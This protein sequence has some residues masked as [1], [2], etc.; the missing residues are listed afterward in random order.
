MVKHPF[1][2]AAQLSGS[3]DGTAKGWVEQARKAEDLG[4]STLLMPDHFDEQYAPI[5]ALMAVADATTTLRI[6]ALVHDNDYRHPVVLAKEAATLDLLSDGRLELGI[7][8]GWMRSDYEH[9]GIAYDP[10]AI[11]VSRFEEAVSVVTGLLETDGPFSYEGTY[12]DVKDLHL[13]PRP[14]Q[15]PRPPLTIGGGGKRVLGIAARTA[16]VVSINVNLQG[17]AA[18]AS[19][20]V[21]ATPAQTKQKVAW[22]K[23]AA[24]DRF[25]DLELNSL[26]GFVLETTERD[27]IL[28]AMATAVKCDPDDALHMPL[29]LVGNLGQMEEEL[30]W[31][32]ENY[33]FSYFSIENYDSL[34]TTPSPAWE[35][36]GPIVSKL[37]G[38]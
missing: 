33:G 11:R 9:S 34:F 36:V 31:R 24:G 16:E 19:V 37:T 10:P 18:V 23:E 7:G 6:G 30:E 29:A 4:Y 27:E 2:F 20:M 12:Y 8:A 28:N 14:A 26:I 32:R 22:V 21:D 3:P 38:N 15:R 1:R 5:P 35:S 13:Q 17:G 25:D